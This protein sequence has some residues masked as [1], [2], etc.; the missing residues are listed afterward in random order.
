MLETTGRLLSGVLSA[1]VMPLADWLAEKIA[2]RFGTRHPP[3]Q[4]IAIQM[5]MYGIAILPMLSVA[6]LA[7]VLL[8]AGIHLLTNIVS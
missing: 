7:I 3:L 5:L 2:N 4:R 8:G 6:L 1:M